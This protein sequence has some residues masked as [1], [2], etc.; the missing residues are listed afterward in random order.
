MLRPI[1]QYFLAQPEPAKGCL[2]FLRE[3]ILAFDSSMTE[4]WQYGMPFYYY[5]KKRLCYLWMHKKTGQSYL[6]IV[7]GKAVDMP[8]LIQEKRAR[9]KIM[10]IDP[11]KNIPV[12][13]I[14]KLL[15]AITKA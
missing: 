9:M 10:L 13:K 6:G 15:K 5:G 3:Y 7:D 8:E 14:N 4:T 12:K 11:S 1:D 2:Q